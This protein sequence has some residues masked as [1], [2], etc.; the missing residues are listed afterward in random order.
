MA[1]RAYACP[2]LYRSKTYARSIASTS[3]TLVPIR[4]E[5]EHEIYKLRDTFTWNLAGEALRT[6]EHLDLDEHRTHNNPRAQRLPSR[7]RSLP[8]TSAPTCDSL[9][10]LSSVRSSTPS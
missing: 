5:I 1:A 4:L 2:T 10:T 8:R 3:E 7:R 9:A 6:A